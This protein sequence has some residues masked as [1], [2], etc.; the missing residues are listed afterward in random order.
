MDGRAARP[1][2]PDG[3]PGS[4]DS[5]D[6]FDCPPG[7][8][9]GSG[10]GIGT[11]SG[12]DHI[13]VQRLQQRLRRALDYGVAGRQLFRT[14]EVC[15]SGGIEVRPRSGLDGAK[16]EGEGAAGCRAR[17]SQRHSPPGL[18]NAGPG[19]CA[20][21]GRYARPGRTGGRGRAR[22]RRPRYVRDGPAQP[23]ALPFVRKSPGSRRRSV[24]P[25]VGFRHVGE[26]A[27]PGQ[28][29]RPR[30]VFVYRAEPDG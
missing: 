8:P 2:D 28:P 10:G 1:D 17:R 25:L 4:P 30:Q 12:C 3:Q 7:L 24:C 21:Q 20:R 23:P 5:W 9:A 11:L 14:L 15:G 27:K 6:R 16:P 26:R 29:A 18:R 19:P 13:F 22:S